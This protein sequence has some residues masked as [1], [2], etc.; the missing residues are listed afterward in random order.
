MRT[1]KRRIAGGALLLALATAVAA[2]S[3]SPGSTGGSTDGKTTITIWNDAL[4]VGSC[5]VPAAKSFLTKG[6][7]PLR[8]ARS[9][10][11]RSRSSQSRLRRL[12]RFDTLLQVVRGGGDNAGHRAAVRRRPG[13]PERPVPRPAQQVPAKSYYELAD[14]LEVRDRRLTRSKPNGSVYAVPYGAGYWYFVYY[15][16]TLF[17]KA[18]ITNPQPTT[19]SDLH[20]ARQAAQGQGDHAVRHSAR[21]R[22]TSGAWTQDA[23]I[24]ALVGDAGVLKMYSGTQSLDSPTLTRAVHRLA[25]AVRRRASPTPTPRR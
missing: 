6:V 17:K 24:S 18:G 2:C 11:S 15:N 4:A 10:A 16:K 21:R 7:E 3:A 13:H 5:G 23:L 1:H 14:R 22:A 12:D 9:P 20:R 8:E 25:R 19:W